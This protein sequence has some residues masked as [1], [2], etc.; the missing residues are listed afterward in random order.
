MT[1]YESINAP[2]LIADPSHASHRQLKRVN[3]VGK[4]IRCVCILNHPI[5]GYDN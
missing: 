5:P 4:I 2:I 1:E 3:N